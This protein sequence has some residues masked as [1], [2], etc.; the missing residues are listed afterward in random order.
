M[1][2]IFVDADQIVR[3]DLADLL[4]IDLHGSVYG[5]VPFCESRKEMDGFR[6][7]KRG[8][9]HDHLVPAGFKYHISALYVVDLERFRSTAAG[10]ILRGTYDQLSQDKN[11]LANLDQDLPNYMQHNLP[12][13][14]L[15][16][17]WLWCETWCSDESKKDG[18]NHRSLQQPHD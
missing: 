18:E 14:S 12:I 6:F 8:F 4:K 13:H 9:W 11:S 7:W 17:D 1:Y 5:F 15:P 16:Q 3:A 2:I 10:D